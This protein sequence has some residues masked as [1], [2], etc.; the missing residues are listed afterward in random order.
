MNI[1]N[2]V[3]N[4][5]ILPAL[6]SLATMANSQ[7]W[8]S[9]TELSLTNTNHTTQLNKTDENP[10]RGFTPG[11]NVTDTNFPHSIVRKYLRFDDIFDSSN[12]T[13]KISY[14]DAEI[15]KVADQGRHFVIRPICYYP[16][17]QPFWWAN[18]P[19][20]TIDGRERPD[21]N[22][23]TTMAKFKKFIELLGARY[24][25]DE[26]L[27][28]VE[29]G[30][31]GSWG[32]WNTSD[33]AEQPKADEMTVANRRILVDEYQKAFKR[34]NGQDKFLALRYTHALSSNP[35][36]RVSTMDPI[37][38]N[39]AFYDDSFSYQTIGNA[40]DR[41][42]TESKNGSLPKPCII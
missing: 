39:M 21:W 7:T 34:T 36:Q 19:K 32:E 2:R 26:R 4:R 8:T 25:D 24:K 22:H 16:G 35:T 13:L 17:D 11:F 28:M 29:L 6:C 20:K 18:I 42:S 27:L 33:S 41:S 37:L 30:L 14:L 40:S 38:G 10:I 31:Y 15:K 23:A 12:D 1:K 9:L 5:L 3:R